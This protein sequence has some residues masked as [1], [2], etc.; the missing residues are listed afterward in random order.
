MHLI[1]D[2]D[3]LHLSS[4]A[5]KMI[6]QGNATDLSRAVKGVITDINGGDSANGTGPHRMRICPG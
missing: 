3:G 4:A 5:M 6:G 2:R 1:Q